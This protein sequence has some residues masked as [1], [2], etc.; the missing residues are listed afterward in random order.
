[1]HVSTAATARTR[2]VDVSLHRPKRPG[3]GTG[4]YGRISADPDRGG[5][6][7][8][9]LGLEGENERI[10]YTVN[11][12]F[13]DATSLLNA[14]VAGAIGYLDGET[15][16]AASLNS[17]YVLVRS[18]AARDLPVQ[19]N[20]NLLGYTDSQGRLVGD[21]LVP[22]SRNRIEFKPE[23]LGFD[24][25]IA[26]VDYVATVV[27]V[28]IGGYL[29]NF[30]VTEQTPATVFLHDGADRPLP[31]GAVVL[32]TDTGEVAGLTMD[33]MVYFENIADGQ[34]LEVD[35]GRFGTCEALV[36]LDPDFEKFD[37]IGPFTCD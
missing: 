17:P 29:V 28:S 3:S 35:M 31:S 16:F 2:T 32:N 9:S 22:F 23:D 5:V 13:T 36:G 37:D 11:A 12:R 7:G 26:G 15:F 21:G 27:P 34:R 18:G 6:T 33:G 24:Y 1:M 25:S 8:L 14:T 20:H 19:L 4:Q 10:A 30:P